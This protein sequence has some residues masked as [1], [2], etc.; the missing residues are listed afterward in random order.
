MTTQCGR[1]TCNADA[2][3]YMLMKK[4]LCRLVNPRSRNCVQYQ[5]K[6]QEEGTADAHWTQAFPWSQELVRVNKDFFANSG[7]RSNQLEAINA[8]MSGRDCFVLMPTGG[9]VSLNISF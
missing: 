9:G 8:T 6:A 1:C 7:F 4:D 3:C 2:L 5:M